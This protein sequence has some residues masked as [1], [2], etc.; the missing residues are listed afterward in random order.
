MNETKQMT[1]PGR[2]L[3][4]MATKRA[5]QIRCNRWSGRMQRWSREMQ[6]R[7]WRLGTKITGRLICGS[8]FVGGQGYYFKVTASCF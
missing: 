5:G 8:R 1:A 4:V 3:S 7:I 2:S 6:F